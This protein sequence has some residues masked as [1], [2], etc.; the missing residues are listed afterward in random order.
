M[1][2]ILIMFR[3]FEIS[4]TKSLLKKLSS[5]VLNT[6]LANFLA[7]LGGVFQKCLGSVSGIYAYEWISVLW[8]TYRAPSTVVSTS[9]TS[10]GASRVTP[11]RARVTTSRSTT[12][13]AFTATASSV[14]TSPTTCAS[15]RR[16]TATST[17]PS[18]PTTSRW[19]GD[20]DVLFP[21][22]FVMCGISWWLPPPGRARQCI[23]MINTLY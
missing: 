17:S 18:S 4:K 20:T 6:Y 3:D 23:S 21:Q 7:I 1:F 19:V 16:T 9:R 12:T 22:D 8:I 11:P 15:S 5:D 14:S 10:P 2:L 13:Q